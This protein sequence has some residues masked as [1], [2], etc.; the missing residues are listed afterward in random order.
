MRLTSL[1]LARWLSYPLRI[2][3]ASE[4]NPL[5]LFGASSI[6]KN[7][8]LPPFGSDILPFIFD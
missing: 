5:T 7:L 2:I 8:S 3:L 4:G 6:F 1:P